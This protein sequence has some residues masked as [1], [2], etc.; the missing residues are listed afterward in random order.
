MRGLLQDIIKSGVFPFVTA[1][2]ETRRKAQE[3]SKSVDVE[4][5]AAGYKNRFCDLDD[6]K[7]W[8]QWGNEKT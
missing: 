7:T 3:S 4:W 1:L 5:E 2:F 6:P 8:E